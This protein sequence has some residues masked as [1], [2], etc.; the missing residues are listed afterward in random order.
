LL[1]FAQG[2]IEQHATRSLARTPYRD[3]FAASDTQLRQLEQFQLSLG[4][5]NELDLT[6]VRLSD[7]GAE[8]GRQS[9]LT[10][11]AR[12]CNACHSNAGANTL[13]TDLRDN[14]VTADNMS[15]DTGSERARLPVLSELGVPFDGGFGRKSF[16]ADGDGKPDAFGNGLFNVQPLIEAADTGPFFHTNA[17]ATLEEA[18]A[19]YATDTF[20]SSPAGSV[21]LEGSQAG[22]MPLTAQDVLDLG[23][24]LRVLNAAFNCQIALTRLQAAWQISDAFGNRFISIQRGLLELAQLEMQDALDVLGDVP[25]LDTP[26][27]RQLLEA[28]RELDRARRSLNQ[29]ERRRRTRAALLSVASADASLGTGMRYQIGEGALMF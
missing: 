18:I 10:G 6:Q 5:R 29:E 24:F 26:A 13:V 20:G 16:D 22:P 27:R 2:A 11:P 21:A 14:S 7:A 17:F 3:F 28:D 4:R 15:F 1:S 8:R 25:E 23:R 9:F 19:F 12:D